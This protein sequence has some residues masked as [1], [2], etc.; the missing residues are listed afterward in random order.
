MEP[1]LKRHK[2]VSAARTFYFIS[3]IVPYR[4]KPLKH[5]KIL[6]YCWV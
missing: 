1:H 2:S 6:Y 5:C 3:E 4:H